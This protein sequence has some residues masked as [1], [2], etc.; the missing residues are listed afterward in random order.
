METLT[1][2]AVS[3][4]SGERPIDQQSLADY[5][6]QRM[7]DIIKEDP[8]LSISQISRRLRGGGAP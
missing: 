1:E 6:A 7:L 2:S 8:W 4:L 3:T 5:F